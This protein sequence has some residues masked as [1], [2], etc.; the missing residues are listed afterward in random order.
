MA[1][2][3]IEFKN[4]TF[5]YHAQAEP[6]LYDVSFQIFPGEKVL[7]AGA[8]GF[9]KTTLLRL[10]NG[11]IP[12]AYA[13]DISGQ[14][15]LN[16]RDIS[17][18]SLFELSLQAGTVLQDAD[19]QFVGLT[20]AEDIAFALENDQQPVARIKAE[21]AKWAQRFGL[22]NRLELAPQMLSG[23]QKQRTAMAGVLVDDG[24]LLLFDEPLASLDPAAGWDAMT[25][26]DQLQADRDLTVVIIEHRIEEVLRANVD[27]I[28]VM[29]EGRIVANDTPT[30]IIQA[31]V[32]PQYGLDEPLYVQ[33]LRQA[34]VDVA[35]LPHVADVQKVDVAAHQSAIAKSRVPVQTTVVQQ[36]QLTLS[37]VDFSYDQRQPLFQNLNLTINRG[38][39]LGLSAKMVPVKPRYRIS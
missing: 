16:V 25:M 7:I 29:S 1:T 24:K 4:V 32:M 35:H 21:V 5:E 8:S 18:Q 12:H 6:T 9:G 22:S 26:I 15:T 13:G 20:V 17:A 36:P 23:G 27:R 39:L 11:L 34:Q 31:G 10:L 38:K 28:I 3:L 37:N 2:P 33:L 30:A 14:M 19:A